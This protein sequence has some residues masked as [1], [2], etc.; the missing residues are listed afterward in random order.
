MIAWHMLSRDEDYAFARPSLT[1]E[2]IRKL[3]LIT[4]AKHERRRERHIDSSYLAALAFPE[5]R[6]AGLCTPS[7]SPLRHEVA[8]SATSLLHRRG[9]WHRHPFYVALVT[10]SR[11]RPVLYRNGIGAVTVPMDSCQQDSPRTP[12]QPG[13][14]N[15][16]SPPAVSRS[17]TSIAATATSDR[18][19]FRS[20][21]SR[22]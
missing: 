8:L 2:K 4:G 15:M 17:T 1:R 7:P 14:S 6:F 10:V 20:P 19:R 22:S 9:P 3:E 11:A 21:D 13:S 12:R 5:G 18:S 16:S